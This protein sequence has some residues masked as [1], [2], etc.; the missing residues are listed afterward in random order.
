[1]SSALTRE[2]YLAD[3]LR[4]NDAKGY[5]AAGVLPYYVKGGKRFI[6]MGTEIRQGSRQ[7]TFLAGKRDSTDRDAEHTAARELWEESGQ[8]LDLASVYFH[9]RTDSQVFWIGNA[10]MALFLLNVD[11]L[12]R[13][14]NLP[15][16]YAALINKPPHSE[17]ISVHWL[18]AES[19]LKVSSLGR[20]IILN[21]QKMTIYDL[22]FNTLKLPAL[23]NCLQSSK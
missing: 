19:L 4:P 21:K 20:D 8:L 1:M 18:S 7:L 14:N 6:M 22:A 17:M 13:F 15:S 23:V 2:S 11:M 12:P 3:R 5:R 9:L 10:K 16:R